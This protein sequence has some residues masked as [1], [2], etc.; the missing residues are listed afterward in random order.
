MSNIRIRTRDVFGNVHYLYNQPDGT[1]LASLANGI[2][3][4][5]HQ[6]AHA[7]DEM[8][9]RFD[10]EGVTTAQQAVAVL[11]R[12]S[13]YSKAE[14][15]II[16]PIF[17]A[18]PILCS[19]AELMRDCVPGS[20]EAAGEAGRALIAECL[21]EGGPG[22]PDT[23]ELAATLCNLAPA[24]VEALRGLEGFAASHGDR[25]DAAGAALAA[26]AAA[27]LARIDGAAPTG[28]GRGA[29]GEGAAMGLVRQ[30][31][32][33]TLTGEA[34]GVDLGNDAAMDGLIRRARGIVEGEG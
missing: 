1:W 29:I 4:S 21:V 22:D 26:M 5:F 11:R 7:K 34:D 17:V 25:G 18:D 6:A 33:S 12:H 16:G 28:E 8:A 15:E 20:I 13:T 14:F 31:A 30:I 24:M 27:I 2:N 32:R 19:E 9:L 10:L 23:L 3:Y